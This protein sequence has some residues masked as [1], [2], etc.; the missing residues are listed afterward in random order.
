M[1]GGISGQNPIGTRDILSCRKCLP[2]PKMCQNVEMG[3]KRL[4]SYCIAVCDLE[5]LHDTV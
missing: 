3:M 1:V 2:V 5:T 4:E